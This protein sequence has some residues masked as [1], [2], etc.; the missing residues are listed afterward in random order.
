M[1]FDLR[2]YVEHYRRENE[3]ERLAIS[4]RVA[5]AMV[6]ARRMAE[7]ILAAD[8]EARAV[9]LFGSLAEGG[10]RRIDFDIDL[11]LDGG[12]SYKAMDITESSAFKVDVVELDH[13]PE[14]VRVRI[15]ARGK[16]LA[17]RHSDA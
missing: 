9:I 17:E 3:K 7:E 8:P 15:R 16:V 1:R 14:H 4:T 6:E 5:T 12:D 2:P 11:A 10:P 13:L